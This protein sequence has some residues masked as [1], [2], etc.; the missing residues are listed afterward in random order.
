MQGFLESLGLSLY[1][2]WLGK[3][4]ICRHFAFNSA[5]VLIF[6]AGFVGGTIHTMFSMFTLK[7]PPY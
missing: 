2:V 3:T 6:N 4:L 7:M 5:T 1:L